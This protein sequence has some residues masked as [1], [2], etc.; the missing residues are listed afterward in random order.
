ME[1]LGFFSWAHDFLGNLFSSIMTN[2][3]IYHATKEKFATCSI[4]AKV[5]IKK[6]HG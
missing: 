2:L 4:I 1:N 6:C 3:G 5:S